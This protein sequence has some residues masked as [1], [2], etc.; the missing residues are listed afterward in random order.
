MKTALATGAAAHLPTVITEN[1]AGRGC[2]GD[3]LQH[4]DDWPRYDRPRLMD[5]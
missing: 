2:R 4:S 3:A 1:V 5:R